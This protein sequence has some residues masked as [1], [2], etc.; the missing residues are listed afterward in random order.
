MSNVIQ[1]KAP[2]NN[3][4]THNK[5]YV[6]IKAFGQVMLT[7]PP[8]VKDQQFIALVNYLGHQYRETLK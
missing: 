1:L 5:G 6:T 2:Q 8:T 4:T 3:G 7:T